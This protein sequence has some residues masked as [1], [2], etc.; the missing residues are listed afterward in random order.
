MEQKPGLPREKI[1]LYK[2]LW[3]VARAILDYKY[4]RTVT[5][6]E[7]LPEGPAMY[8]PNHI[9]FVDSPFVAISYTEATGVP[10][11]FGAKRE[12]FE[13]KGSD[14][15]GKHG[16]SMKWV[17][18]HSRMIP[19]NRESKNPRE[20]FDLLQRR[21]E[22]AF[23]RGDA[24]ALHPEGT[25][26]A[27]GRLHKFRRGAA[28]IAINA[29]VPIVPVGI[30]YS[31]DTSASKPRVEI[32]FGEPVRPEEYQDGTLSTYASRPKAEKVTSIIEKRVADLTDMKQTGMVAQLRKLR[33]LHTNSE[34]SE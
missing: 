22:R 16:R 24:V 15:Q 20:D 29:G 31:F 9:L 1:D 11:R 19:V 25:R 2:P 23:Q 3:P 30:R 7:N 18:E 4:D 33:H 28:V 6:I 26:S 17:M 21:A 27:D 13:G 10:M 34:S 32:M 8:T 5:G 12:Y 14:D